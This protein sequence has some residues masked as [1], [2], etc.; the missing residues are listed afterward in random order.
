MTTSVNF[1]KNRTKLKGN[2]QSGGFA[3]RISQTLSIPI[4]IRG[5]QTG[6]W[7]HFF[8]IDLT[9]GARNSGNANEELLS[10]FTGA[11]DDMAKAPLMNFFQTEGYSQNTSGDRVPLRWTG[12]P[13]RPNRFEEGVRTRDL[14]I[15]HVKS[16]LFGSPRNV[17][18]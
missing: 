1:L 16:L 4:V 8:W 17:P 6:R 11:R 9:D 13:D 10:Y 7:H 15:S 14:V 18:I 5:R 12:N 3:A 2:F